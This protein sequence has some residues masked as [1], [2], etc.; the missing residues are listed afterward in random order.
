MRN[1]GSV[2]AFT[3]AEIGDRDGWVCGICQD[4]T[5]L[6]DPSSGAPRALS[7]SIDHIVVVS[8][9]G[10]HAPANV[11]I[12]HLWCNVER[13]GGRARSPQYMRARLS[14]VLDGVPV[15]EELQR[16]R[17]ASWRWPAS[18]RV[19]YM[20]ALYITAGWVEGDPRY[21]DPTTRLADIAGQRF[22][23]AADDAVRS[24]LQWVDKARERRARRAAGWRS[25]IE[26]RL[27]Q[28]Q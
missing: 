8:A 16:S 23:A 1:A 28:Q 7:P 6:V 27:D 24:G 10:Q 20:I 19:E 9:G 21:G 5:R 2:E 15:P 4:G 12:T 3:A 17:A 18:L 22:G 25:S 13:G 14:Q 11:R 26:V